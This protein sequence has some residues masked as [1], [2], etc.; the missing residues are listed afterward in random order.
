M[1]AA[2]SPGAVCRRGDRPVEPERLDSA[3]RGPRQRCVPPGDAAGFAGLRLRRRGALVRASASNRYAK[4]GPSGFP[5][6][7][8]WGR[9]RPPAISRSS[10]TFSSTSDNPN[11]ARVADVSGNAF[12]TTRFYKETSAMRLQADQRRGAAVDQEVDLAA[13]DME[14]CVEPAAAAECVTASDESQFHGC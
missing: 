3:I 10:S 12:S 4:N 9:T 11:F 13:G 2:G 7:T 1:A 8:W 5:W 14:A 6:C